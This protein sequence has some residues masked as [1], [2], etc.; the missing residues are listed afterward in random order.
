MPKCI[1]KHVTL[2]TIIQEFIPSAVQLYIVVII[3]IP[4]NIGLPGLIST[5]KKPT[6]PPIIV[7][8]TLLNP[9]FKDPFTVSCTDATHPT[10]ANIGFSTKYC[11]NNVQRETAIPVLTVLIPIFCNFTLFPP[12]DINTLSTIYFTIII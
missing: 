11:A 2:E 12:N 4:A 10:P 7:P 6:N 5:H 8:F 9:N 1:D 3:P